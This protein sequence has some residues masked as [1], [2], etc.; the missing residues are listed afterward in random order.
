MK[1]AI[2]TTKAQINAVLHNLRFYP[3]PPSINNFIFKQTRFD[4]RTRELAN[5]RSG[6]SSNSS[7]SI[8]SSSSS[9][10]CPEAQI[11]GRHVARETKVCAPTPNIF[12]LPV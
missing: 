11:P 3:P 8:S 2:V 1:W 7:S 12:G 9:E 4:Y 5:E 10:G 6:S